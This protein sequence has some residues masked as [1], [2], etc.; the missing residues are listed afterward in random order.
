MQTGQNSIAPE[1]SLPQL[2]QV[3]WD[4]VFIGLPLCLDEASE[5]WI[6]S[7]ISGGSGIVRDMDFQAEHTDAKANLNIR[8]DSFGGC[9]R[10][11]RT[12]GKGYFAER[13]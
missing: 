3:R 10:L 7:A 13:C 1:N 8:L 5:A 4:S 12:I 11:T 6:S 9:Y 2:G